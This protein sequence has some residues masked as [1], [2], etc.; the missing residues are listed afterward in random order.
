M[1]SMSPLSSSST[2]TSASH[3]KAQHGHRPVSVSV[4]TCDELGCLGRGWQRLPGGG[5]GGGLHVAALQQQS[6][7]RN[8]VRHVVDACLR[9]LEGNLRAS[10]Q[11]RYLLPG[12]EARLRQGRIAGVVAVRHCTKSEGQTPLALVAQCMQP[13][14]QACWLSCELAVAVS[15]TARA[16]DERS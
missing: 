5:K 10:C 3:V 15:L 14:A 9:V 16:A 2:Y 6:A 12:T 4:H 7:Q 11:L 13:G 1:P 8:A